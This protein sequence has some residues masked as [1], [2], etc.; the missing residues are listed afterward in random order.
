M[1]ADS[2]QMSFFKN[3]AE[4]EIGSRDFFLL[5]LGRHISSLFIVI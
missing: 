1:L 2:I 4:F 5:G 3:F